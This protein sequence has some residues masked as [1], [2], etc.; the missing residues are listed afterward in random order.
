MSQLHPATRYRRGNGGQ[1]QV[2]VVL[3]LV[4]I[5]IDDNGHLTVAVDHAPYQAERQLGRDDLRGLL[6]EITRT[7]ASPVKVEVH[8]PDQSVFTDII[9]PAPPRESPAEPSTRSV[10]ASTTV[11]EH[12]VST[13]PGEVAGGGFLPHEDV[14]IAV[15]VTH[16]KA[17]SDGVARLRLPPALLAGRPGV[18]VLVGSSSGTVA[19]SGPAAQTAREISGVA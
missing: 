2:P 7:L 15:V 1:L 18:V 3:P 4:Q 10:P 5:H 12:H 11:I 14:A 19:L 9:T 6:D 16:Q 13:I 8:E 17:G